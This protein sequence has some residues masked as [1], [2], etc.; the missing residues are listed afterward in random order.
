[1]TPRVT[2]HGPHP[3]RRR[4]LEVRRVT[5]LTPHLRRVTLT[6]DLDGFR[7]EG[8]DDHVKLFFPTPGATAEALLAGEEGAV[9]ARRDYTPRRF[10]PG[11]GELDIEFALHGD[12]PGSTWAAHARPGDPLLLGGPRGSTVVTYDFD[13]YLLAGD[14]A[15]QPAVSRRLEE[16]PPGARALVFLEVDGPEGEVPLSTQADARITWLHRSGA[17]PGTTDLL[18]RALRE[19][20]LPGGDVFVWVGCESAAAGR[21]RQHLLEE[22]G[23]N[24]EWVRVAGYWKRGVPGH[25]EPK[26]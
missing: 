25:E 3:V 7:S 22:R 9:L 1:M 12:G 17:A 26:G 2:R 19:V 11:A 20:R 14:E 6:G 4:L 21:I 18:E 5:D 16:L 15:A 10:D 23:L 24:R 13:A 8:A